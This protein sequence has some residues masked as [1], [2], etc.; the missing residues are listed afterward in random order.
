M[1]NKKLPIFNL[2]CLFCLLGGIFAPSNLFASIMVSVPYTPQNLDKLMLEHLDITYLH[3]KGDIKIIIHSEEELKRL[4]KIGI[5]FTLEHENIEEFYRSRLNRNLPMGGYHTYR[6]ILA[7]L[8][9]MYARYPEIVAP[10]ESIGATIEG[11][12]IYA[13]KISDNP[14]EDEDEPEVLF[15]ALIHAREPEGMEVLLYFIR[16]LCQ[17]YQHDSIATYI[18]NNRELYFVP[19]VNPDG[20]VY[21]ELTSPGG[22]GVWRKNRRRNPDGSFGV[23]LNRNFGFMWGIDNYGS[24]PTPS[25]ETYR[26]SSPFSEPETQAYRDFV[27]RHNFRLGINYHAYGGWYLYPWGYTQIKPP[28]ND[29]YQIYSWRLS[30]FANYIPMQGSML[31]LTNGST[32]DW[33]FG[34][35]LS[36]KRIIA[37]TPEVG[38]PDDGFWPPV[39]R[40]VQIAERVMPANIYFSLLAGAYLM[41]NFASAFDSTGNPIDPGESGTVNVSFRNIGLDTARGVSAYIVSLDSAVE[42]LP[43]P[44]YIGTLPPFENTRNYP[45]RVFVHPTKIPGSRCYIEIRTTQSDGFYTSDTTFFYVGTPR[46]IYQN[47]F[48]GIIDSFRVS[49]GPDWERGTPSRGVGPDSAYSP[50]KCWGTILDG[51]Y[52]PLSRSILISPP[53]HLEETHLPILTF[54]HW[55][56]FESYEDSL[57]DGGFVRVRRGSETIPLEPVDGYRGTL[58]GS[59]PFRGV[60]AYGGLSAGWETAYFDLSPFA[61]QIIQIEF[62]V[63]TDFYT[64]YPGWYI[65]DFT[66]LDYTPTSS[67]AIGSGNIL[68]DKIPLRIYPNPCNESFHIGLQRAE[69]YVKISITDILGKSKLLYS[70]MAKKGIEINA[71]GL[72]SGIY[73]ICVE[74]DKAISTGKV[75]I[76]K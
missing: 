66:I 11:R 54:K 1:I 71:S 32:I 46:I 23:D 7:F 25:D 48:D 63:G 37:F 41:A 31:Y 35:T 34:D 6:E 36:H 13:I 12:G 55:Y 50:P 45:F 65:D 21:N 44:V 57:Y 18:V 4:K 61:G 26:G 20:Y 5:K 43:E 30:R 3:P 9:S 74:S 60:R 51:N 29:I 76:I 40:I 75:V 56:I 59:N 49:S 15:D 14:L 24:S 8:D 73:F 33:L 2:L 52:N 67:V 16:Y 17:Q 58:Y 70:G 69:G 28:L 19:V 10:K 39:E 38:G 27:T 62:V 47:K 64:E 42:I 68:A 72:P 22:G 53:I